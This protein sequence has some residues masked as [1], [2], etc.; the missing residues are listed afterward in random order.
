MMEGTGYSLSD[1][2]T[3]VEGNDGMFGTGNGFWILVLFLFMFGFGGRGFGF[4]SDSGALTRA[5]MYDGF[6]TNQIMNKLNGLE[7]G[8]CSGFYDV[9]TTMLQGFNGVGRDLCNIGYK[10]DSCC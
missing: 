3:A 5:E 4:G 7:N 10:I 9:N 2:R 1:I 8:L 6:N